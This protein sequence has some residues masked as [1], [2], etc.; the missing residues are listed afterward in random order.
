MLTCLNISV[1]KLLTVQSHLPIHT[2]SD[3]AGKV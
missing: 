3:E 2:V 1:Q